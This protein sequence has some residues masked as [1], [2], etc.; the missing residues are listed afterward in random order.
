MSWL[1]DIFS[2]SVG[3]VVGKVGEAVDRLALS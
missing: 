3:E 1:S 2:S